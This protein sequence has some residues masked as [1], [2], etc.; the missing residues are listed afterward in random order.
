VSKFFAGIFRHPLFAPLVIY[1]LF[2]SPDP[3]SALALFGPVGEPVPPF[4]AREE[5]FQLVSFYIPAAAL[6]LHF[7]FQDTPDSTV[8]Q[9]FFTK[10]PFVFALATLL[11][12]V[13]LLLTGGFTVFVEGLLTDKERFSTAAARYAAPSGP[14]EISLMALSCVVAAYLEEGFFR[15]LLYRRLLVSGL[16]KASAVLVSSLLFAVCHS[17]EGVWGVAGAFLSGL[18]LSFLFGLSKS[19]SL[20]SFS[21]A[22]YN[23]AVY[24]MPL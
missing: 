22:L 16:R 17:W 7:C 24:L 15:A 23:I 14:A 4:S 19:L 6:V 10:R 18:L 21:H 1:V 13:A 11:G 3:E 8:K 12:A 5:L 2:F 9:N 20:V